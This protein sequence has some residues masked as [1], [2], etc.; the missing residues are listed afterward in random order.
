V[1]SPGFSKGISKVSP[2]LFGGKMAASKANSAAL[3]AVA[4][5]Y[6]SSKK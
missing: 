5:H 3:S 4:R 2:Q 6:I 1:F